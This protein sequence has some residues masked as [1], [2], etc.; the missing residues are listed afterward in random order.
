MKES[1]RAYAES[2]G[3]AVFG[4]A[5]PARFNTLPENAHPC[6]IQPACKAVI[7]VGMPLPRGGFRGIE[8]GTLWSYNG[9]RVPY[10]LLLDIARFI[11]QSTGY[12]AVA[13]EA[14]PAKAMPRSRPVSQSHVAPNVMLNF[15]WAAVAA[16]LGEIGLCGQLLT[17]AYG[18]RVSLGIVL[19]DAPLEADPVYTGT[20]CDR[21]HCRSCADA[22]PMHAIHPDETITVDVAGRETVL[23][24]VNYSLCATCPN[25]AMPDVNFKS[26]QEEMMPGY[27]GNQEKLT[28]TST[29]LTRKDVPNI[30]SA[31]CTRSCI[32]HLE[33][34]NL[35]TI[36]FHNKFRE[37]E[38]WTLRNWER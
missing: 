20:I 32:A 19:T 16:G 6:S 37:S 33:D 24:R 3:F 29:A 21:A 38:P 26:G 9:R 17:P 25:G 2:L 22:C 8:E 1:I 15:D 34:N 35:L 31:V 18:P 14:T 13:Y 27:T 36:R 5:D 12:E 10:R 7:V 28:E 11:E 4:I 23:A 30:L